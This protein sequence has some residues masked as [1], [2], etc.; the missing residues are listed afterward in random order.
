MLSSSLILLRAIDLLVLLDDSHKKIWKGY[1]F[2]QGELY[3]W[4]SGLG[5]VTSVIFRQQFLV[6]SIFYSLLQSPSIRTDF[7]PCV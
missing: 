6:S 2:S 7:S 1:E 4:Q 3:P 5:D